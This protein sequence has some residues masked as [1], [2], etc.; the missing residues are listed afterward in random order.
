VDDVPL[1]VLT[2]R[3]CCG[4]CQQKYEVKMN[5]LRGRSWAKHVLVVVFVALCCLRSFCGTVLAQL[6]S[7]RMNIGS[8]KDVTILGLGSMGQ[9]FV[10]CLVKD[11]NI[12]I[13]AWNRGIEKRE[14]VR[15]IANI[16]ETAE[17]AVK[18]SNLTLI[19]ID[20]WEGMIQLIKDI[21]RKAWDNKIVV[22]FSTYTPTDILS[23]QADYFPDDGNIVLV[24][25]AIVGVPQT[26]CSPKAL[27]LLSEDI[28]T[29]HNIGR[30]EIFTG[31]VG[32]AALVN[33]ALILVITFGI[34]GQELA[35]LIIQQ[36]GV[37][38]QF[39]QT[40]IP[41]SA[42]IGPDYTRMLLPMVSKAI[43]TKE[44]EKS[45]VPV[46]VFRG[47]LKMHSTFMNDIGIKDDTFLASYLLYL[48]KISNTKMGPAAWVEEAITRDIK[49]NDKEL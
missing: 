30:V 2:E 4:S 8:S 11:N 38:E 22:L 34:A 35:H 26:I 7:Q 25:G 42:D 14:M 18:A 5:M 10:Q 24:G 9:A 19:L 43:T 32:F 33:M 16:Y 49:I 31:N 44:Y 15:S 20:D 12:T 45:Y 6:P 29:L 41:L 23:L 37:S 21:D 13:H 17:L 1:L 46:A 27:V 36:Y 48:T 40:Y 47:V 3:P 28:P 39:L